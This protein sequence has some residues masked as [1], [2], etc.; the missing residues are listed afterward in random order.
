MI[1]TE[2]RKN[3]QTYQIH[4]EEATD[5]EAAYKKALR[6]AVGEELYTT[7][8]EILDLGTSRGYDHIKVW[9]E[10]QNPVEAKI[11]AQE[12]EPKP[13]R[14]A[15]N[16]IKRSLDFLG[17]RIILEYQEYRDEN[18]HLY[19]LPM[20]ID[21]E[22][23]LDKLDDWRLA[24]LINT[25]ATNDLQLAPADFTILIPPAALPDWDEAKAYISDYIKETVTREV[26]TTKNAKAWGGYYL[27]DRE[28]G[29]E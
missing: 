7:E 22:Y 15:F 8:S 4:N 19:F 23:A 14:A 26:A 21:K 13:K 20:F 9:V 1:V 6:V 28:E 10:G 2:V 16:E 27:N 24:S 17:Q 18:G 25:H 11:E 12:S 3:G 29:G 5:L